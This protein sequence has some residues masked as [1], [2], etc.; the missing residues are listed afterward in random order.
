MPK[1]IKRRPRERM[2]PPVRVS[3]QEHQLIAASA[4]RHGYT[5]S[6]YVRRV[7]LIEG[8]ALVEAQR[9]EQWGQ[10]IEQWPRLPSGPGLTEDEE[11][12]QRLALAEEVLKAAK[13]LEEV[14]GRLVELIR[15]A[16]AHLRGTLFKAQLRQALTAEKPAPAAQANDREPD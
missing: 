12:H 5:V 10:L 7:A 6:E 9:L 13:N 16:I 1:L 2:L 11:N 15:P 14:V 4:A 8:W 3:E